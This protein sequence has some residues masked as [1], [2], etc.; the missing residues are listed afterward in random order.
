MKLKLSE[1]LSM[2]ESLIKLVDKDL[3]VKTAFSL[4]K[5][6]QKCNEE[7]SAL[8]KMRIKLVNQFT[9]PTDTTE[10][11]V[12]PVESLPDFQKQFTELLDEKVEIDFDKLP[13]EEL[14]NI[15]L[16]ANDLIRLDPIIQ[17]T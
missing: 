10:K 3:P 15:E 9:D 11:K 14:G 7:F 17:S 5:F 8:E 16:S 12:V 2:R 6:I 4:S 1:I 13:I